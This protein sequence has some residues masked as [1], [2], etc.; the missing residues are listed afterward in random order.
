MSSGN[1]FNTK[2]ISRCEFE[3]YKNHVAGILN[4]NNIEFF[5]PY[6]YKDK[7]TFGDLDIIVPKPFDKENIFDLFKINKTQYHRNTN[8]HSICYKDTQIDFIT[9]KPNYYETTKYYYSWV[10][11]SVL[12]GRLYRKFNIKYGWDGLY[13]EY[14]T[15]INNQFRNIGNIPLTLDFKT[16]LNFV[17]LDYVRYQQGFETKNDIF[18]FILTSKYFTPK[19]YESV[20]QKQNKRSGIYDEIIEYSKNK[21]YQD[22][23]T[24]NFFLDKDNVYKAIDNYF[25]DL[26]FLNIIKDIKEKEHVIQ[27]NKDKFNGNIVMLI[28]G[29]KEKALA[30]FIQSF[31]IY[32]KDK[33]DYPSFEKYVFE[34]NPEFIKRDILVHFL[35]KKQ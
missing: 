34:T 28:T 29:L 1:L 12:L 2:R 10:D 3:E 35:E 25:T 16:V 20:S 22:T 31:R 21:E 27:V 7:Q 4:S 11:L 17:G 5:I 13:F 19:L 26:N 9:T 14:D 6:Y 24:M 30:A 8:I 15:V 32:I 33:Y 18:D 23:Y